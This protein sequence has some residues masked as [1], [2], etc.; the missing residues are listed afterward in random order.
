MLL[1]SLLILDILGLSAWLVSRISPDQIFSAGTRRIG[2]IF[3]HL[4]DADMVTMN[5]ALALYPG[6]AS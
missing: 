4:D 2:Q 3:G 6:I 5:H 1:V